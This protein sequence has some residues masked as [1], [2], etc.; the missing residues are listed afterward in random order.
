MRWERFPTQPKLLD[1][2]HVVAA[3]PHS[4]FELTSR[5]L[6][7]LLC[8]L[9]GCTTASAPKEKV[10]SSDELLDVKVDVNR[11]KS[12]KPSTSDEFMLPDAPEEPS[13]EI[14][15]KP[16]GWDVRKA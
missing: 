3:L 16:T 1:R 15:G 9:L 7:L 2:E 6:L 4:F 12:R 5:T 14:D 11:S 13:Y 8:L 10:E